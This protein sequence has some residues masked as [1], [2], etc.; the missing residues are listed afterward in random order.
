M[1][2][3]MWLVITFATA[4]LREICENRDA[5]SDSMGHEAALELADRLADVDAVATAAELS[6]LLG[7]AVGDLS[8]SEKFIQLETGFQVRFGSAHVRDAGNQQQI[9]W[10]VTRRVKILGIEK[11]NG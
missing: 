9:D 3:M 8:P 10:S 4:E 5:A 7:L 11:S 2:G 1:L 6:R